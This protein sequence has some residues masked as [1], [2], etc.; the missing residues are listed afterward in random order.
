VPGYTTLNN[1]FFDT[2]IRV[3]TIAFMLVSMLE[4]LFLSNINI[5]FYVNY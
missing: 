5:K 1:Y 2:K 4:F 3:S